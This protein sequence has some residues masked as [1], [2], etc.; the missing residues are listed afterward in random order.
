MEEIVT[1]DLFGRQFQFR[2]DKPLEDCEKVVEK[3]KQY[4]SQAED[5]TNNTASVQ[6]R[7][8]VL[9]LAGMNLANDLVATESEVSKFH[10][11]VDRKS[12]DLLNKLKVF[13]SQSG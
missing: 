11:H 3:L 7:V 6:N 9:L 13:V 4:V 12:S 10:D 2:T 8:V 5:Q 1:I